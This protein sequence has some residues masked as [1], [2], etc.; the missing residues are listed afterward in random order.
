MSSQWSSTSRGKKFASLWDEQK[1]TG[2]F[3]AHWDSKDNHGREVPSGVYIYR[4][5]AGSFVDIKKMLL[6][7]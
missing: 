3:T 4:I 1:S 5:H 6:L 2:Y 7:R